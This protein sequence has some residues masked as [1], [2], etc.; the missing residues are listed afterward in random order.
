MLP[1]LQ[2]PASPHPSP[3]EA[4]GEPLMNEPVYLPASCRLQR[5]LC[6]PRAQQMIPSHG[7]H[8]PPSFFTHTATPKPQSSAPPRRHGL[9]P[10]QASSFPNTSVLRLALHSGETSREF[11]PAQVGQ[12]RTLGG[13]GGFAAFWVSSIQDYR[14]DYMLMKTA[15]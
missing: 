1:N 4:D 14:V 9:C 6:Q 5:R 3:W 2:G 7:Q 13:N 12:L 15:K 8:S 11:Q 10:H